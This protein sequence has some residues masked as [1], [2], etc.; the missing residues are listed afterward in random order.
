MRYG[1]PHIHLDAPAL[2]RRVD[3]DVPFLRE[4]IGAP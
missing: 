2:R 1:F 4:G 3:V